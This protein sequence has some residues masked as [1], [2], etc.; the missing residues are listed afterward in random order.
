MLLLGGCDNSQNHNPSVKQTTRF[1]R[2]SPKAVF[3]A[4]QFN[5][6]SPIATPMRRDGEDRWI[7]D[8]ALSPGRYEYKFVVDGQWEQDTS[9]PASAPDG[10]DG[11]NSVITVPPTKAG[12]ESHAETS[13]QKAPPPSMRPETRWNSIQYPDFDI[14]DAPGRTITGWLSPGKEGDGRPDQLLFRLIYYQSSGAETPP[15]LVNPETFVVRLHL[16]DGSVIDA[17]TD[18]GENWAGAG[19]QM[20]LTRSRVYD[21]PWNRNSYDEAWIEW[22]L[23]NQTFWFEVP[24]G[25]SRN[26]AQP[27]PLPDP[28]RSEPQLAAAMKNL[29]DRDKLIAW[30]FVEYDVGEIQ[31]HW[32]LTAR[33]GNSFRTGAEIVLYHPP[34][35]GGPWTP[36]KPQVELQLKGQG[37]SA[38]VAYRKKGMLERIDTFR[39]GCGGPEEGRDTGVAIVH[40]DDRSYEFTIPSSLCKYRH[41]QAD[42]ENKHRLPVPHELFEELLQHSD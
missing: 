12:A 11:L 25:F 16:S 9:N 23:P 26:P 21:F 24:Y 17:K 33:L 30:R 41:G 8:V 19:N 36:D 40:V 1:T 20:G 39:L 31:N 42:Y 15:A 29:G 10:F 5:D 2:H 22:R 37:T 6:W 27:W 18:M 4:G 13:K 32:R 3:L 14:P 28:G 35:E 38:R 34:D 7:A